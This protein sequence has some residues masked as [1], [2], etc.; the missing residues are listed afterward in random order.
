MAKEKVVVIEVGGDHGDGNVEVVQ[1][2]KGVTVLIKDWDNA[3]LPLDADP[4][5]APEPQIREYKAEEVI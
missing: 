5:D 3:V 1:K 2:P 4:Q